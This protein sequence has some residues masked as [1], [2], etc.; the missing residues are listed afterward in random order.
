[1]IDVDNIKRDF[2]RIKELGFV[3]SIRPYSIKNDG[4]VG[5]TFEYFLGVSENNLK[6]ADYNGW[7]CKSQRKFTKSASSLFTC[8]PDFPIKGDSYMREKWGVYDPENQYPH[9][10]VFRTSLYAHRWSVVYGKNKLKLDVDRDE[11]KLRIYYADLNENILDSSV[12]WSFKSLKSAASK[13]KN[14]LVVKAD[15]KQKDDGKTYFHY[16]SCKAFIGFNFDKMINLI[17]DGRARYDNRL[18]IY[19]S[20]KNIGKEH[21]HGGGIRLTKSDYFEDLF[22]H[23]IAL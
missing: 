18:G 14:T 19:R 15:E 20:G 10:K 16:T 12:Y 3:E 5:N 7:E 17:E 6:N 4:A 13:L 2:N 22:D 23:N 9:I 1:M 21:N 11:Q 8:K